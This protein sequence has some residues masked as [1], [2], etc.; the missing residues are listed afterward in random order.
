[1]E[2]NGTVAYPAHERVTT[3]WRLAY[4]SFATGALTR[5][6]AEMAVSRDPLLHF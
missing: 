1:M 4:A 6:V 5:P 2:V 3:L